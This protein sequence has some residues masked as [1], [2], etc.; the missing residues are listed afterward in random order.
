MRWRWCRTSTRSFVF[1]ALPCLRLYL[2]YHILIS[3]PGPLPTLVST[4]L[5][6]HDAGHN[7]CLIILTELW[8][9]TLLLLHIIKF[10]LVLRLV[11]TAIYYSLA[12][13]GFQVGTRPSPSA[14]LHN[15]WTFKLVPVLSFARRFRFQV[16]FVGAT[17]FI[18]SSLARSRV[19]SKFIQ[20]H[21]QIAQLFCFCSLEQRF[22]GR[23]WKNGGSHGLGVLK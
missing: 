15:T 7:I 17:V 2:F 14:A 13:N 21:L 16:E 19:C 4:P 12:I 10:N 18:G 3:W 22:T 23:T 9:F 5:L 1:L 8:F 11:S 20:V 6:N